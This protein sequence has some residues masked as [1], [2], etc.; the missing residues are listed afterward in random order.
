MNGNINLVDTHGGFGGKAAEFGMD[1]LVGEF[2]GRWLLF[3]LAGLTIPAGY[4]HLTTLNITSL[5]SYN[6][7][8]DSFYL[9]EGVVTTIDVS[10]LGLVEG[11]IHG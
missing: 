3:S 1:V 6:C 10:D 11:Y 4:F 8:P 9:K 5:E 7:D 2:D